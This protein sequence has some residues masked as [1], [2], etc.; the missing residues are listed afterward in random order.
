MA[1]V[2]ATAGKKTLVRGADGGLYVLSKGKPPMKLQEKDAE[3]LRRIL[4]EAEEKLSE[5][6]KDEVPIVG[7]GVNIHVPEL[8]L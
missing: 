3:N 6:L 5:R 7:A 2:K 8:L 4:G 1:E